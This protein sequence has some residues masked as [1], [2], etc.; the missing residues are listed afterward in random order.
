MLAVL[1]IALALLVSGCG[2]KKEE[3]AQTTTDTTMVQAGAQQPALPKL[4]MAKAPKAIEC[5]D[6]FTKFVEKLAAKPQPKTPDEQKKQ[7]D[8]AL[9]VANKLAQKYGFAD[10][11][12]LSEY[13]GIIVQVSISEQMMA[14]MDK[15]PPDQKNSPQAQ[16][17]AQSVK[18]Q[19][20]QIKAA[21]G[22]GLFKLVHDNSA[23]I[24][25]FLQKQM[26]LQ[27]AAAAQ[28]QVSAQPGAPP[29]TKK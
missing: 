9:A 17:Q 23:K 14:E 15:L 6:E 16:M 22:E 1:V 10:M 4:D 2:K 25:A 28:A 21:Y 7:G 24:Q 11:T 29:P 3:Q 5:F 19:L 20:E 27:Q 13:I 26:A 12:E 8:E 18:T